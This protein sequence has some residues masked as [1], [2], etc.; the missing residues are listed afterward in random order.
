M[1][2]AHC[3]YTTNLIVALRSCLLSADT[4]SDPFVGSD[5]GAVQGTVVM[6]SGF[7]SKAVLL[8]DEA[9]HATWRAGAYHCT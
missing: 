3:S 4:R 2:A 8:V 1:S 5:A 9:K 6:V 7:P